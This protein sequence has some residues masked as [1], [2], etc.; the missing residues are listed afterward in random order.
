M[1]C[2]K[3]RI[4]GSSGQITLILQAVGCRTM[5]V[6]KADLFQI[7]YW[8][9]FG[10]HG[11]RK[12]PDPG[13]K[14]IIMRWI[15]GCLGASAV[16]FFGGRYFARPPPKT[17]S[18]EWQELTNEYMKVSTYIPVP[19]IISK[20]HPLICFRTIVTK[21]GTHYRY[22]FRRLLWSWYDSKWISSIQEQWRRRVRTYDV[23]RNLEDSAREGVLTLA[24]SSG[25]K[26]IKYY[27]SRMVGVKKQHKTIVSTVGECVYRCG[28]ASS[29]VRA[30]SA[31]L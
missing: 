26:P 15:V 14:W 29:L 18:K 27:Y 7:A 16:L 24:W 20:E 21:V 13:E 6:R 22:F 12:L 25:S 10:P 4:P 11:P 1:I 28:R 31:S 3:M 5:Y 9:A 2:G 17:M 19:V 30:Y 8:I 23:R